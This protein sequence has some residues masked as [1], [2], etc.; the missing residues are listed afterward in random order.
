MTST[1]TTTETTSS[2]AGPA[3]DVGTDPISAV[4]AGVE[5]AVAAD[6]ANAAASVRAQAVWR[7][8]I[9]VDVRMGK[10]RVVVDQPES[11]G[12][13]DAGAGPVEL[14]L[15]ALVAC[16]VAIFRFH[17]A[18]EG[19]TIGDLRVTADGDLDVRGFFGFD[20]SVRPGFSAIRVKVEVSGPETEQA[21]RA[22]AATVDAHCPVLDLFSNPTPVETSVVVG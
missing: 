4:V 7:A 22:L 18:K 2:T 21:Y 11:L 20:A 8:P 14:A 17:A 10:H 1:E 15:G 6:P 19:L 16:Q 5:G 3:A 13:S 9:G 12:G